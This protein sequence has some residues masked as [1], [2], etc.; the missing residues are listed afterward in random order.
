MQLD[1][2]LSYIIRDDHP[3][4]DDDDDDDGRVFPIG[5]G[6]K[7]VALRRNPLT[8]RERLGLNGSA[9]TQ[10]VSHNLLSKRSLCFLL[11]AS[12]ALLVNACIPGI[13]SPS[14]PS[15][16]RQPDALGIHPSEP[17]S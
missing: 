13:G 12:A 4:H 1:G 9:N 15:S 11:P 2:R 3:S 6:N 5:L 8:Y 14:S 17:I 7:P 10:N 16:Q